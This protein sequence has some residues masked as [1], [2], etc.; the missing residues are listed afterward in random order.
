MRLAFH[1]VVAGILA[2]IAI[3][4]SE[5]RAELVPFQFTGTVD[6]VDAALAGTFSVGQTL[7]G[8]YTIESTTLPRGGSTSASAVFDALASLQIDL[9]AY[10]AASSAAPE[11]QMDNAAADRYA[12]VARAVDGL[13]GPDVGGLPLNF[14]GIRLDDST[15][16]ALSDALILPTSLNLAA[17]DSRRFFIFF[18]PIASPA[19]V[20]GSIDTLAAVPEPG[21]VSLAALGGLTGLAYLARR[22]R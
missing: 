7:T 9:G 14:F 4:V 8:S 17:F 19:I 13:A 11:I 20:G 10:S 15:G 3:G 6:S 5:A 12:V 2:V 21:S 1:Q 22:R 18:G 16:A